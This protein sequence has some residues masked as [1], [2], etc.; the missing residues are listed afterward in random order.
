MRGFRVVIAAHGDLAAALLSATQM[1]CGDCDDIHAVGLQPADSPETFAERLDA[2]AG[3]PDRPL[4]ILCDLIGGTP[5]NVALAAV[6]RRPSAF[7]ISGVNLAVVMEA[8][9]GLEALDAD[10]VTR[11]VE[12]GR[13][14]LLDSATFAASRRP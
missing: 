1:I 7:L 8:A 2:A 9:M 5:H 6:R 13:E 10:A 11:L 4:L 12:M 14:A 3:D